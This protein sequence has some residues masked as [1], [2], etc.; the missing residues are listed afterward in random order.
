ML[1]MT[2]FDNIE[3]AIQISIFDLVHE[4]P[5]ANDL[6]SLSESDMI[7]ALSEATGLVFKPEKMS[8]S[9][10]TWFICKPDKKT[11]YS[12]HLSRYSCPDKEGQRIICVNYQ[13]HLGGGGC[14]C[15]SLEEAIK[16]LKRAMDWVKREKESERARG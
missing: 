13:Y 4:A 16:R 6:E 8:F 2:L 3:S 10:H 9:N 15:E 11:E 5:K 1:Q 14:P 12:V 7:K